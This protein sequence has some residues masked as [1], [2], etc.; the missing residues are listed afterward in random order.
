VKVLDFGLAK[1]FQ[2]EAS[3]SAVSNSPTLS[4]AATNAGVILGT[5][6]Y[7][8]PEQAKGRTVDKRTD[9]WALGCVIP[10][11]VPFTD[12]TIF[13]SSPLFSLFDRHDD[14]AAIR[15]LNFAERSLAVLV[16]CVARRCSNDIFSSRPSSNAKFAR[17]SHEN[18][19][20]TFSSSAPVCVQ[21]DAVF[22]VW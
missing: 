9:I 6:A 5:A 2:Q 8:S 15:P 14:G 22:C 16:D 21:P 1:A 19:R 11:A 17:I 12:L 20:T 18:L 3:M 4:M 13:F 10:V 7:M